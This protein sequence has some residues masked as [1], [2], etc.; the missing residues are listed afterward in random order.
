MREMRDGA[1]AQGWARKPAR[2]TRKAH[3]RRFQ[4]LNCGE[5]RVLSGRI[6][7]PAADQRQ[8]SQLAVVIADAF[9]LLWPRS[10][11]R[12]REQRRVARA[13]RPFG[14]AAFDA[15]HAARGMSFSHKGAAVRSAHPDET[16]RAEFSLAV[17]ID[18]YGAVERTT[19]F[20]PPGI[21]TT[22][23]IRPPCAISVWR[24]EPVQQHQSL[25]SRDRVIC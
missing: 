4:D 18:N 5:K 2:G 1:R 19:H 20:P 25:S 21:R 17:R 16:G 3:C 10:S 8:P 15:L 14:S 23:F 12:Q 9:G 11:R 7:Q 6:G 22:L 24:R 13:A